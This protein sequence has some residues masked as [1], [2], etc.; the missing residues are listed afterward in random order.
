M[1]KVIAL[2]ILSSFLLPGCSPSEVDHNIVQ[3][4]S[5]V[6]Y[7]PNE[8]EPFSGT[9]T[10]Y[11]PSGQKQLDVSY[12][13]GMPTGKKLEWYAN[14]QIKTEQHYSGEDIGRIR[15]WYENGEVSRDI[16]ILNGTLVGKNVWKSSDFEG[17]INSVN[18]LIDG[19]FIYNFRDLNYSGNYAKG[20]RLSYKQTVITESS[21]YSDEEIYE[22]NQDG[23]KARRAYIAYRDEYK[24]KYSH[25]V[26][27][28]KLENA[29]AKIITTKYRKWKDEDPKTETKEEINE[30]FD[31]TPIK[32]SVELENGSYMLD[33]RSEHT[34]YSLE[35]GLMDGPMWLLT[36][37]NIWVYSYNQG[38]QDG[39]YYKFDRT[40]ATWEED[41]DCYILGEYEY[42]DVKCEAVFG[43]PN[44]PLDK[45]IPKNFKHLIDQD[46]EKAAKV[47]EEDKKLKQ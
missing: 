2:I 18:G 19:V 3:M 11:Y 30:W 44:P 41:L 5:G 43:E 46:K 20:L 6:A 37:N 12:K 39:Y 7:L 25:S 42:E 45:N 1:K 28:E 27:E 35:T 40:T 38:T 21:N 8:S 10:A 31:T 33:G 4:R 9:A 15:D 36:E 26:R 29:E 47:K 24:T 14:G 34:T 32:I 17:E 13:D 23:T 22:H 16:R